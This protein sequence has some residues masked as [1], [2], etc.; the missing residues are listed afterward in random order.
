MNPLL[1]SHPHYPLLH[2]TLA[3]LVKGEVL[4]PEKIR[5]TTEGI[6]LHPPTLSKTA[7]SLQNRQHPCLPS[8]K[9]RWLDSKTQAYIL[10]RFYAIYP[11][12][13]ITKSVCR[14]DGGDCPPP[15]PSMKFSAL[16]RSLFVG[17][18]ACPSRHTEY[19]HSH[20]LLKSTTAFRTHQPSQNR[21]IPRLA[22]HSFI[23]CQR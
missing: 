1:V 7:L 15:A 2:T 10:Q 19:C 17:R 8:K 4:S 23:L 18:G 6:A 5:A 16:S 22:P 12:F 14:Q 13:I 11:T 20:N 21:T 3:S 9:G